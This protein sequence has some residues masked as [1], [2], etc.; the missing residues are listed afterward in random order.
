MTRRVSGFAGEVIHSARARRRS[1]SGS[2]LSPRMG[3]EWRSQ[4]SAPGATSSVWSS[5][6]PR[7]WIFMGAGVGSVVMA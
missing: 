6:L 5:G 3:G 4:A 7:R 2:A 1:P